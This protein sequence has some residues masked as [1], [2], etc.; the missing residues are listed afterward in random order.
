MWA[1]QYVVGYVFNNIL[2]SVIFL[3]AP[4]SSEDVMI[5]IC[6]LFRQFQ[7]RQRFNT[8]LG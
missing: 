7:S 1:E 4:D 5:D 8:L 2:W 6:H 3:L